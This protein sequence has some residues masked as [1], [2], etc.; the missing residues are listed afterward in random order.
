MHI[1][2]TVGG[3]TN[4]VAK[5]LEIYGVRVLGCDGVGASSTIVAGIDWG[6]THH[7]KPAVANMSLAGYWIWGIIGLDSSMDIAVRNPDQAGVSYA[8]AAANDSD[9]ACLCTPARTPDGMTV[10]ARNDTDA[11]ASFSNW[12]PCVDWFAPAVCNTSAWNTSDTGT[13]TASGTSMAAPHTAGVATLYLEVNPTATPAQVAQALFDATRKGIV[14]GSNSANNHLLCSVFSAPSNYPPTAPFSFEVHDLTVFFT[15]GRSSTERSPDHT[16][17]PAGIHSVTLTVVDDYATRGKIS[18]PVPVTGIALS[19]RRRGRNTVLL[20]WTPTSATV[21]IWRAV[22][23]NGL[24]PTPIAAGV[25][26]GHYEDTGLGR[27]PKS[28]YMYFICQAGNPANC[29][30]EVLISF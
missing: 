13:P 11:R 7:I 3:A 18:K 25:E 28:L 17:A 14:T 29:S 9:D 19:G 30:N 16:Y 4:G 26:G 6:T 2:G 5:D 22:S 20:D 8:L 10:G 15:D 1:A 24:F 12:G 27:K 23:T 21:D